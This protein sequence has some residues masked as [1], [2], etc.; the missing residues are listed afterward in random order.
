MLYPYETRVHIKT[1]VVIRIINLFIKVTFSLIILQNHKK[2][3]Q[4]TYETKIVDIL[5]ALMR[6]YFFL[7]LITN[8][9]LEIANVSFSIDLV[10][11]VLAAINELSSISIGA[12]NT[13]LQPTKQSL[14]ILV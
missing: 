9:L 13:L 10:S 3:R 7:F 6:F 1:R 11:V 14:P 8:S 5:P 2:E 12:I 4:D